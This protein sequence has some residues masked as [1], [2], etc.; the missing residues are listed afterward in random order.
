METHGISCPVNGKKVNETVIRLIAAQVVI[1]T[2]IAAWQHWYWI[3]AVLVFDFAVRAFSDKPL[4]IL[5]L[6]A[7]KACQWLDF[8][9]KPQDEAPKKFAASIGFG[10]VTALCIT[11]MLQWTMAGYI[12]AGMLLTFA[13]LE[14]L[15][16]ICV[17]CYLYQLTVRYGS[18]QRSVVP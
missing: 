8:Q 10:A 17:G 13:M 6:V 3:T 16:A 5:R 9:G 15:F 1:L 4:S 2:A 12:I 7:K 18:A 14:W 11:Q